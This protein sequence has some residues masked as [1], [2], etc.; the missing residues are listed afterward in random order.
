MKGSFKRTLNVYWGHMKK[1][2]LEFLILAFLGVA[3]AVCNTVVPIYLKKI[4]DSISLIG[5]K[6]ESYRLAIFFLFIAGGIEALRWIINRGQSFWYINFLARLMAKISNGSFQYLH[7][8]S[9]SFFANNFSGSLVKKVNYLTRAAEDIFDNFLWALIPMAV[10]TAVILAVLFSRDWRLG[11]GI[12]VWLG[13]F[14]STNI[15][16]SNWKFKYNVIANEAVSKTT[17][18]LADT[19]TNFS[20]LKLFNGYKR[21]VK[22]FADLQEEVRRKN[23]FTWS[24]DEVFNSLSSLLMIV[25]EVGLLWLSI[26]LWRDGVFTPGDFVLVQSYVI[27]IIGQSWQ[28]GRMLRNFYRSF[29][30]AE[31]MVEILDTEPEIGD[32]H[33]A[34]QLKV[35]Q[36]G[37]EFKE[38]CFCYHETRKVLEDFNLAI[39]AGEKVALIGPSGAGKTTVVKLLLR[40]FNLTS[41]QILIDGQDIAKVTQE[42]LWAGISLVPQDPVL[43]HRTLA[44]NIAYGRPEATMDEIIEASKQAHCHEFISNLPEG[45]GTFVGERGI[46]LSGGERQR[47]AIARA[48]LRNAPILILDEATSSLDSESEA[49]IQDALEKLMK[50]KT[51]IVIAHRLSTIREM[52]RIIFIDEGK[53]KEEGR[54]EELEKKEGGL[55]RRL[56]E[57]QAC[58][59]VNE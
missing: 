2:R 3:G 13:V 7:R 32:I 6:G 59:F 30:D 4:V 57:I 36:G 1:M 5:E 44:E 40:N 47:V 28:F 22:G 9:F 58:G 39:K 21:E 50:D 27:I 10:N 49:L 19:I 29:S 14:F 11:A 26:G 43:F 52:D 37:I 12:L 23:T 56:W 55:Y 20:S 48:I 45:Y 24:M 17:G 51:V 25:L 16:F 34:G 53:I 35:E 15:F 8:H 54:H 33:K 31:E 38:V 42:S 46:K 18:F 41:G